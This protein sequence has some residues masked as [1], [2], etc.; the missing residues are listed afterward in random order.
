MLVRIIGSVLAVLAIAGVLFFAVFAFHANTPLRLQVKSYMET[1]Q[2]QLPFSSDANHHMGDVYHVLL[3]ARIVTA[4]AVILALWAFFLD[5]SIAL[6][7]GGAL[8][9]IPVVLALIPWNAAF[10]GMH[11]LLF[12]QGD[13]M[14]PA[15][16]L[17]IQTYPETFFVAYAAVWGA[18]CFVSGI[19]LLAYFRSVQR[20]RA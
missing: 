10:T 7:A 12:P 17:I 4:L 9:A 15:S 19:G 11:A 14:F 5:K 2:G 16:S 20:P 1:G 6:W 18:L 8:A 13:W 3:L